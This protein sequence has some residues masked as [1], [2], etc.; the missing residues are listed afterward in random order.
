[1]VPRLRFCTRLIVSPVCSGDWVAYSLRQLVPNRFQFLPSR[2]G[3]FR[4]TQLKIFQRV[5]YHL[6]HDQPRVAFVIDWHDEPGRIISAGSPLG[7]AV[8][9]HVDVPIAALGNISGTKF[10]VFFGSSIRAT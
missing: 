1:M 5:E 9:L 3:H 2:L 8:G 7:M 6:R 4:K 10:P